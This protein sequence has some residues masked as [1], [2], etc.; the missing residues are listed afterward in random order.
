MIP[1]FMNTPFWLTGGSCKKSPTTKKETLQNG[2]KF[3]IIFNVR[4][5]RPKD[6]LPVIHISSVIKT[7][8]VLVFVSQYMKS[9]ITWLFILV[10]F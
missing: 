3:C 10:G 6:S 4:Y 9:F 8:Q 7:L 2:D 1:Y 5:K